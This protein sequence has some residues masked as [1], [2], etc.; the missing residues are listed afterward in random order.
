MNS[1]PASMNLNYVPVGLFG[2]TMGLTGLSVA[3]R[4]AHLRYGVAANVADVVGLVALAAFI[5]T[6][7]AYVGKWK[8]APR[9]VK[10][11]FQHP[12]AGNMFGTIFVSLLLVP[13]VVAPMSRLV[14]RILWVMGAIGI[15]IF[16]W[17]IA[18]R[19][20]STRQQ[21]S[22][23]TP[24]WII[25]VIGLLD[26][27]LAMPVLGLQAFHD[28][29]VLGLAVGLFFATPLFTVIFQRQV[30]EAPM[31]DELRPTLLILVAPP[32]VGFSAYVATTGH[33][34]LFAQALYWVTMF[35]LAIL[36]GQLRNLPV[37]CPFRISWWAVSFPLAACAIAALKYT[38]ESPGWITD[39][40][41]VTLLA[42]MTLVI[43]GLLV[44][45]ITGIARGELRTLSNY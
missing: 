15:V 20:L 44:R 17:I 29:M 37:C 14:A 5:A 3:W 24:A 34:D 33:L 28:V 6:S 7:L 41:A 13:F 30:F 31:P 26:I 21:L 23:A 35:V 27:P 19:W 10:A 40:I 32:A 25:P 11:E 12:I 4:L 1:F 38:T 22:N 9:A 36:L 45:T 16:A 2:S 43:A 42:L 18:T 39:T 8:T